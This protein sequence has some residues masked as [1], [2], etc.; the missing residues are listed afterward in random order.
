MMAEGSDNNLF[1]DSSI[2][3]NQQKSSLI[4]K[5][6]NNLVF[7]NNPILNGKMNTKRHKNRSEI[8]FD[9]RSVG[10]ASFN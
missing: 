9:C 5:Y 10:Q 7:L 3:R 1:L 4:D 6:G 2:P 8:P